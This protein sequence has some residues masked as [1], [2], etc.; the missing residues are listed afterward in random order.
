[1]ASG[2]R[3]VITA[4]TGSGKS[5]QIPQM[6]LASGLVDGQI[7]VL[8]PRRLACRLLARRVAAEMGCS[9][10]EQ[11][12]YR[13]RHD[14]KV[15]DATCICFMTEGF[16]LRLLLGEPGLPHFSAVILDEFHERHLGG[17]IVLALL[18]QLQERSR[19]DLKVLVMSATLD[20]RL[21]AGYLECP[22]LE[23][24]G[25]LHPVDVSY[26]DAPVDQPV[27]A[28][29]ARAVRDLVR[30]EPEGDVLV[31]MPG[32]YEIRRTIE[33]CGRFA[34]TKDLGLLPLYADLPASAQDAAVGPNSRRKVIVSTNVAETSITIEG[35]RHVVDSGLVKV[36]RFDPRRGMNV[37]SLGK[38]SKS[39]ADQRAGRAGR[40]TPGTCRRLWS[41]HEQGRKARDEVPEVQRLELS[42]TV[43]L[44]GFLGYRDPSRFPWLQPPSSESLSG[45]RELLIFLGATDDTGALTSTGNAMVGLPMH[46]RLSRMLIEA[47]RRGAAKRGALWAALVSERDL[48]TRSTGASFSYDGEETSDFSALENALYAA[49]G[50]SYDRK[51]CGSM[52]LSASACRQ[53]ERT[54]KLFVSACRKAGLDTGGKDRFEDAVKSLLVAY[55]DHVAALR[56][57]DHRVYELV[58]GRRC[59]LQALSAASGAELI[60]PVEV[61]DRASGKGMKAVLS[62]ASEVQLDWLTELFPGRTSE[63]KG[64]VWDE[65][66]Q[67]ANSMS[68]ATFDGLIISPRFSTRVDA[69]AAEA[70]LAQKI[71]S[72]ELTLERWD[73][74][75]EAWIERTRCVSTWFPERGL[76][77]YDEDDRSVILLELCKG[78][79]AYAHIRKAPCLGEVINALSWADR[80]FVEKMAP[81]RIQ[82]PRGYRMKV[83]YEA[84]GRAIGR[85][86]IQDLY[87]LNETPKVGGGRHPVLLE[88]LAPNYRPVQTTDDLAGFWKDLYPT[89]RRQLC[90]RYPKHEWK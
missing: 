74:K 73:D 78:A 12:G 46:P 16:L 21:V 34:A 36:H 1:M 87:G 55:P 62:L 14:S 86:K 75:V 67:R 81:E 85:A 23:A 18:K 24:G 88:I 64:V 51:K 7:A 59:A 63:T 66:R 69:A 61:E 28:S 43:L 80:E 58:G 33:Q 82:L 47:A 29:A 76:L 25:R 56:S 4:P 37:L 15:S 45:A 68:G 26:Q 48:L 44:L 72:G 39:S 54:R 77:T 83:R 2:N 32:A 27:W 41:R 8:Q 71:M 52:G 5:T 31:F 30:A 90:R 10:G 79:S 13:T 50:A 65:Q 70:L 49:R 40:T 11:V 57:K 6:L 38:V 3:A 9:P 42:E 89:V 22:V 20:V 17:D 60:V 84:G 53:V 35:V 19:P